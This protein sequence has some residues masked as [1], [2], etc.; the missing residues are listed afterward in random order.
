MSTTQQRTP[1]ADVRPPLPPPVGWGL[2]LIAVG[3]LWLLSLAGVDLRWEFILPVSLIVMGLL[4][5]VGV[6]GGGGLISVGVVVTVIAVSGSLLPAPGIVSAGDRAYTVVGTAD[7]QPSY[8][9]GAGTLTL[10]LR[11]LDLPVGTTEVEATVSFGELIVRVPPGVTID[12]DA[13]VTAGESDVFGQVRN[14]LNPDLPLS[15]PGATDRVLDL[16]LGVGFG[17]IEVSR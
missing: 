2:A 13:D 17:R 9:L 1:D 6:R 4:V 7:L 14:G 10:D 5:A 12:G 15:D 8:R 16:D 3:V 11:E